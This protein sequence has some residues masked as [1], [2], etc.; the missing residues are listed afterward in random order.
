MRR[1]AERFKRRLDHPIDRQAMT[2]HVMNL[3]SAPSVWLNEVIRAHYQINAACIFHA[4]PIQPIKPYAANGRWQT[5][6][7]K[8]TVV[9]LDEDDKNIVRKMESIEALK[10]S[11][12]YSMYIIK[13]KDV[14]N[15][16]TKTNI[17]KLT[18]R[19]CPN[20]QMAR[21]D[22]ARIDDVMN[23]VNG[24]ILQYME[25]RAN[26]ASG[27]AGLTAYLET[28]E[29]SLT[30]VPIIMENKKTWIT[31]G[32]ALARI[33]PDMRQYNKVEDVLVYD[34][35]MWKYKTGCAD[36]IATPYGP[37][38]WESFIPAKLES[39]KSLMEKIIIAAKT[40]WA[41]LITVIHKMFNIQ[42]EEAVAPAN[43]RPQRKKT[44]V[45]GENKKPNSHHSKVDES[46]Q[47]ETATIVTLA[48]PIYIPLHMAGVAES[49]V[50]IIM[51]TTK[52]KPSK[53]VYKVLGSHMMKKWSGA[54][55]PEYDK[56]L[57]VDQAPAIHTMAVNLE[58][59][60][61]EEI[62]SA[63]DEK[64]MEKL[65]ETSERYAIYYCVASI[66][67]SCMA[68]N[69]MSASLIIAVTAA[70]A[71]TGRLYEARPLVSL[72]STR[73]LT[74]KMLY[75]CGAFLR[76][77]NIRLLRIFGE[78]AVMLGDICAIWRCLQ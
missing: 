54:R 73:S 75:G 20:D 17:I 74:A 40:A 56:V 41:W 47:L 9:V 48:S 24:A 68:G 10:T 67:I 58:K 34:D 64:Y 7:K 61:A 59:T 70:A 37:K 6:F 65:K 69:L 44:K 57:G 52:S 49:S 3:S 66:M 4:Q 11:V 38:R 18:D 76:G 15:K 42:P 21:L 33:K 8:N 22:A 63:A 72:C 19:H 62:T 27:M 29:C 1:G 28:L 78:V 16:A 55:A 23:V 43:Q 26:W 77:V 30:I 2:V 53:K 71:L 32:A 60:N 14:E 12:Q 46:P 35:P 25:I 36:H 13:K 50:N 39:R 51:T 45:T 5:G 31:E